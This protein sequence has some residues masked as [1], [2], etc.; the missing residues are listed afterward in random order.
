MKGKATGL[1]PLEKRVMDVVWD[2]KPVTADDVCQVLGSRSRPMKDSTARTI[3]RRLEGKGYLT[4]VVEGRTYVYS[5]TVESRSVATQAVRGIIDRFCAGSVEDLLVGMVNDN[6]VSA[7]K[8]KQLAQ[9]IAKAEDR[10]R[11]QGE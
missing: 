11:K 10:H 8:L 3:L 7:D 9:R 4:H 2:K 1:S 6:L 5:P